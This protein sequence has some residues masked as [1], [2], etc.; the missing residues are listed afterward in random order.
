MKVDTHQ[1]YWKYHPVKDAWITDDMK[2]LQRDFMPAD[3]KPLMDDCKIDVCV[4]V[5][6]DQ[7]DAE[8]TF[9]LDLAEQNTFIAGV[10]G[11]VD[12]LSKSLQEKL[13]SYLPFTKLKGFRHIVQAEGNGFLLD[14]NFQSGVKQLAKFGYTYDLLIKPH[15]LNEA[16][17][18]LNHVSEQPIVIDHI[19]KPNIKA[20]NIEEWEKGMRALAQFPNVLCKISGMVTEANWH[21][22]RQDDFKHYLD[23]IVETFGTDRILFGSDWPV[24]LVAAN[25]KQV[26]DLVENYF[27]SFSTS[28][29]EKFWSKNA[30][31]FYNL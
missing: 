3:V 20:G 17:I 1:H 26:Y 18:F 27:S 19:A 30:I 12:L 5:Q 9:L 31:A 7:S 14:D 16:K 24:C 10:V 2:R 6:A 25:Y 21:S 15:Q 11:W 13:E 4:A 22:W 29:Q 23:V 8:T 28:E